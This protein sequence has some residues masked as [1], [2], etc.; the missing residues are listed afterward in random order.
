[1]RTREDGSPA[2]GATLN[3]NVAAVKALLDFAH[4]VGFSRFNA[5]PL[6]KIR[7]AKRE[8]AQRL[9]SE[10]DPHLLLRATKPG[11]DR[12]LLQVAYY[13]ALRVSELA[14]AHLGPGAPARNGPGAARDRRLGRQ[15][16]KRPAAGRARGNSYHRRG[17]TRSRAACASLA[18][19]PR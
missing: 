9:L 6:I 12:L 2:S 1:M 16:A 4:K 13:G 17:K 11:R 7:K 14:S 3:T 10:V 8:R 18:W 19:P 15:A 5:T